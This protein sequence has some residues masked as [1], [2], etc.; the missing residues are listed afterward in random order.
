MRL[1]AE[2]KFQGLKCDACDYENREVSFSDYKDYIDKKC[3]KCGESLLTEADYQVCLYLMEIY[4]K[5]LELA[6]TL[7]FTKEQEELFYYDISMNG[8]G[9]EGVEIKKTE[10]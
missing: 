4:N 8:K 9:W 5:S 7:E 1:I 10:K 3:P 6:E 2:L